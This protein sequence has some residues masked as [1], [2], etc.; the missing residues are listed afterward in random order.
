MVAHIV[1]IS[2][3][4]SEESVGSHALR[5]ILFGAIP[6]IIPVIP[7]VL[8][9]PT[10][11]IVTSDVGTVLVV[12]PA[13]VFD[14]VD[15]SS[16][17]DS[18]PS[19]DSLPPVPDLPLVS[20]FLC[21]DDSEADGESEP[22]EQRPVSSSHDTL[23]PLSEFPLA[24]AF[25]RW[26]SVPLST[27]YP[28][29]TSE[30]SL[31]SSSERSL[32]SSSLSYRPSHKRCRSPTALVPSPTH[33]SRSIA[34]TP[35]VLL[36]PH[37]R[38]RDSYSSDDSGEEHME[39]DTADAKA[40]VDVGISE[41]VVAH[42]EDGVGMGFEI[43]ASDVRKDDE[44]F[45]AEASAADMRE[46]VVDPLAI[47]DTSESSRGASGERASLVERIGSLRLEYLKVRAMLSIER[48]RIDSIRWH[49]AL[50]QEEFRQVR[51][52]RDDTRR[53]LRRLESTMTITRS[54]MTP[55][56]IEEL[57]NRRVEEALAAH[58]V[59]HKNGRGDRHVARECTYQDFMKCQPLNFKGTKG[60]VGLIRWFEKMET[61]FHINS[62]RGLLGLRL[63]LA[64]SWR[65]LMKLM[66]EV[67]CPRNE[68]QKMETELWN[69][70]VKKNDLTA[71]TQR[72]QELTMMCTKMVPEEEDRVEKFIGGL[73]DNIQ[74][75]SKGYAARNAKNKRDEQNKTMENKVGN[76]RP[77]N[78][79][80]LEVRMLLEPIW[81]KAGHMTRDCRVVIATTTQG[82]P[83]PNQRVITCFECEAQ[84][85]YRKY[86]PKVKNQNRGNKA[87]VPDARGKA[88]V[89][90]GGD[91]NPG[92]NTVTGT[93]LLN[94]HHAYM[95][96]DSG[97]D[98]S[99]ISD[100]FS[101]L[102]DII[103]YA[104]DGSYAVEL[105]NERTL[106]TNTVLR[107]CTL[108]LLG[109]PF[110]IDLMPIDLGSFD[111]IIGMNWLA[112]NHA[113]IVC[114]EKIVRITYGNEILI[115]QGDKSDKE[116][117]STL[118]IISCEKAQK[119]M[120]KGC[121]LFLAQVTVK[122][123]KDKLKKK[124]LEDVPTVRDFSEVFPE[125]LP[126]LPPI[127][128]VEFQIELVPGA[129]PVARAPYRLAPSEMKELIDDL[130]DQLQG[131]SVYSKIDLR[132]GYHQ[133]RVR[134]ED[135]P[136]TEFRTR[137]GHYEFQVM[138]FG[139]TNAS[140]V[141]MDLMNRTN[142]GVAQE[143][144]IVRQVLEVR[145]LAV[146]GEKEE[147]A[148]QIIESKVGVVHQLLALP[149]GS[150]NFIVYCDAS[151][152]GLG[153]VLMQKEKVIA[154]ASCQLKIHEKNYTTHDLENE[155]NMRL[156]RWL[157]SLSDKTVSYGYHQGKANMVADALSRKS[158]P[159]PLRVQA[160]VTTIGLNL[161]VQI[162]N[163]QVKARKEENY[164]TKDLCGMIK[165][166]EPRA[167]GTL[168]LKNR[169]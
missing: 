31:G 42:L 105:A 15:H 69:L 111:I 147:T 59:T 108:G 152:K 28:P 135:I 72:F 44:E 97:A 162:L 10:D 23:A 5:V 137:Y 106:E 141:F 25:R 119:Y 90:G 83:G 12:S 36:P 134:D 84:G 109:H 61:V 161:P 121:Q 29:T 56:A 122:E 17:S 75:N 67:Y 98:R 99:F 34:P 24:P 6:A 54:G 131:S 81:L 116:K 37:K 159:K 82:T 9:V 107:G 13:G 85:H 148:F 39:V 49:M 4:S 68:I 144:R 18:D 70:T 45:E 140:A 126:G 65:E 124:R 46:I 2:S 154:Y 150:E 41:G 165:N 93:F 118:S 132:S 32:D 94:D 87:R 48:D 52:D 95:L 156:R 47:G 127:R 125:D 66:T 14:L 139:L 38:F 142:F 53:R 130:F 103:P 7:E 123:N 89:L 74:G 50:S 158:R 91:A 114:D 86:Y 20:P 73:P 167:D 169:S 43:A 149:E 80:I 30:S 155:L 128:Q 60:V 151:H 88:Y 22:A 133:L 138:P 35:T 8:I 55:E 57:V 76:N 79:R 77:T 136:K 51:R 113:V 33:V 110:N 166:L 164:G 101:T 1:S 26:R 78:D 40:V 157:E 64:M 16:S 27:P 115:V 143:G 11:P 96:F 129:A 145:L 163:A 62:Y 146:E 92:S 153:A 21:S 120:E 160:L 58:E 19:E 100:T 102:L 3:D 168:C 112:K 63:I 104:L 117:K 71:Y